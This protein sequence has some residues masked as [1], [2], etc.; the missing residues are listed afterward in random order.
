MH[1]RKPPTPV[2]SAVAIAAGVFIL[3]SLVLPVSFWWFLLGVGLIG[4][5]IFLRRRC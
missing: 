3:L 2:L 1:H 5:G 4:V